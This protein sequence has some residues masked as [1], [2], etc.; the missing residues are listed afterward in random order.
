MSGPTEMIISEKRTSGTATTITNPYHAP[1]DH[2]RQISYYFR[3]GSVLPADRDAVERLR[4]GWATSEAD[5]LAWAELD[6][7]TFDELWRAGF[8]GRLNNDLHMELTDY[9]NHEIDAKHL[10]ALREHALDLAKQTDTR[11]RAWLEQV[12]EQCG[13]GIALNFPLFFVL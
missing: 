7:Q 5:A 10:A 8:F 4:S 6:R 1:D 3:M 11:A 12:A 2:M 9:S 13:R